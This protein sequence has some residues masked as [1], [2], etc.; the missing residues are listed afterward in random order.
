MAKTSSSCGFRRLAPVAVLLLGA[1]TACSAGGGAT[2]TQRSDEPGAASGTSAPSEPVTM[3]FVGDMH[4][5]RGIR[6]ALQRDPASLLAGV[7]PAFG[8]A[9]LVVGN[10]E[11]AIT[12]RGNPAGKAFTFRAPVSFVSALKDGGIDV[13]SVAN[14]HGLDYGQQGLTDTLA[15]GQSTGMPMIGIGND[16]DQAFTP[17]TTTINGQRIAVIGATQV[18][19]ANLMTAWTA[20]EGKPGMASAY[21][22]ERLVEAVKA[23]KADNDVVV[24]FL[25]WGTERQDCPNERQRSLETELKA[26]GA[27]II[28]GSHAHVVLGGGYDGDTYVNY[29]LGNFL[30]YSGGRGNATVET[31]VQLVTVED[32]KVTGAQWLPGRIQN[33]DLPVLL[34]GEAKDRADRSWQNLRECT[35]LTA[36]PA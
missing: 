20:G 33:N 13:V 12:D 16:A 21:D 34:E 36:E 25:H 29:G 10:L 3:A 1:V 6:S 30:F 26:A 4:A 31:G 9:D 24:V 15:A 18:L 7:Q 35:G 17:Y 28:V 23:A 8:Q 27:Q 2:G 19:D 11:T 14:N 5:E 32:G 22:V